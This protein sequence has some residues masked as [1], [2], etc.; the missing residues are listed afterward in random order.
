MLSSVFELEGRKI[1]KVFIN[2]E[3]HAHPNSA[4][5]TPAHHLFLSNIPIKFEVN[6]TASLSAYCGRETEIP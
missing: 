4:K 2:I 6:P 1:G 3:C 5:S